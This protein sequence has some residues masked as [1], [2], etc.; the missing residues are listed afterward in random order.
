MYVCMDGR[1]WWWRW[2]LWWSMMIDDNDDDDDKDDYY[3]YYD[4]DTVMVMIIWVLGKSKV[5]SQRSLGCAIR[6]LNRRSYSFSDDKKRKCCS[7]FQFSF[8]VLFTK[9]VN[10]THDNTSCLQVKPWNTCTCTLSNQQIWK[11]RAL[12]RVS[13]IQNRKITTANMKFRWP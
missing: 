2:W 5:N 8:F 7:F 3:Y 9:T 10:K 1:W 4:H 12:F 13:K 6:W 11:Q